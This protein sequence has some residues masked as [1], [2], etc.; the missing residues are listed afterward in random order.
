MIEIINLES[1]K[2]VLSQGE[3]NYKEIFTSIDR[4]SHLYITTFNYSMPEELEE[5]LQKSIEFVNDVKVIFNV[6]N[7]DGTEEGK[8]YRLL[9]KALNKNPYVQFFYNNNNHSKIIS[10]GKK[11]YIGSSN[12]TE[13]SINNFEAG[14][15]IK[16]YDAIREIEESVFEYTYIKYKPIITDPIAPLIIPFQFFIVEAKKQYDVLKSMIESAKIHS[17]VLL[18]EELLKEERYILSDFLRKYYKTFKLAKEEFINY[19][20]EHENGYKM[21][22]L[23]ED[24]DHEIKLIY[25]HAPLGSPTVR[26]FDFM[27]DYS[28]MGEKYRD[29]YWKT[30][31]FKADTVVLEEKLYLTRLT[32][33]LDMFFHLRKIWIDLYGV[34]RHF[35]LDKQIPIIF[36]Y[37]EPSMA[38]PYWRYF[39]R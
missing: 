33:L 12:L 36:W 17:F 29:Q 10:N 2:I 25:E 23:L 27:E 39:L 4:T 34:K 11:M 32:S 5:S 21:V 30:Q 18:D 1:I 26:F 15:I 3:Q 13:N 24:I 6:Y 37:E 31:T 20:T 22:N 16:D 28:N 7:F 35:F 19:L 9:V 8:I 38:E 14:V